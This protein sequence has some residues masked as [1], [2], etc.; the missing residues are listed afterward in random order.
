MEVEITMGMK[1]KHLIPMILA[2]VIG[3]TISLAQPV[4]P[5]PVTQPVP[6][7]EQ[8]AGTVSQYLLNS[9]G[10]VDGLLL[11]DGTQ[12]K[13]PPH[14]STDLT[15]SVKPDERIT[16]QG[17]R[18][19]SAVFIAFTIT[20][21]NG[22]SVNEARPMQP[23]PPDLRGVNLKPMQA[24][25]KIRVVLHAPRGEIEGAVLDS[26]TIVRIA[27]HASEQFSA[28]LQTGAMISAKGYGTENEFGRS[29]EATEIGAG[30]Q[31]LTPIYGA[32]LIQPR[33]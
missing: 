5:T 22:Q 28:L 2:S 14:M 33:P 11:A 21:A 23:L 27:P 16:A 9:R 19:V 26:G 32:A 17:V 8:I 12:V 10:E 31:T 29:F 13:F 6:P 30:G 18:E 24:D 15:R 3:A 7:T 1:T 25:G 4:P 20:N